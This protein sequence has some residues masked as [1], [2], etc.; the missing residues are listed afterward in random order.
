MGPAQPKMAAFT[1]AVL[2]L[3]P[4][5]PVRDFGGARPVGFVLAVPAFVESW[6]R[7]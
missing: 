6:G 5:R 3:S 1:P 2:S 7:Q 4:D